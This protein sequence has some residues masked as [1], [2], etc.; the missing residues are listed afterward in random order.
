MR[1]FTRQ[2]I[3]GV[4]CLAAWYLSWLMISR[5]YQGQIPEAIAA[6]IAVTLAVVVYYRLPRS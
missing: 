2:G 4:V 1:E 5:F 3:A 6:A